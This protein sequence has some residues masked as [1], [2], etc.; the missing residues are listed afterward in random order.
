MRKVK[1]RLSILVDMVVDEGVEIFHVVNEMDYNLQDTT[2]SADIL[3][4]EL[5][6]YEIIDSK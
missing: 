5:L 6:E 1:V 3:D 2:E 4:T